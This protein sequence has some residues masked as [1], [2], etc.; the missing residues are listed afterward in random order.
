MFLHP[1]FNAP[2]RG[3]IAAV[4]PWVFVIGVAVGTTLPMRRW[5]HLPGS[6]N[7][8]AWPDPGGEVWRKAGSPDTRYA[9]DVL[10]TIDGD[11]F[12]A[13]VRVEP[14]RTIVTRVR[15]RGIDAPELK[16]RCAKEGRMAETA[17][18]ALRALL[19]EGGVTISNVG[20]D[21]YA[22]R[23]DADVATAR[24]PNVS[25][26]LLSAGQVR[27]YDGGHRNGWCSNWY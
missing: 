15:L 14:N 11:T 16:A 27:R 3:R 4:L 21:K 12:L 8:W 25:N 1:R 22:G 24:T 20:L 9:V 17:S 10:H 2:W 26:A 6:V 18:R 13:R 7:T 23:V 19:D 5:V